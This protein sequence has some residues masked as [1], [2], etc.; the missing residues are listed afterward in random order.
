MVVMYSHGTLTAS[1]AYSFAPDPSEESPHGRSDKVDLLTVQIL[2][3]SP[4]A[5]EDKIII[6]STRQT[7]A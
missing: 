3:L 1:N 2:S 7:Q 4:N 5:A 6:P